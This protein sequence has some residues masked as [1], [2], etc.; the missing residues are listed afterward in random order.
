ME[1]GRWKMLSEAKSR[2]REKM[3]IFKDVKDQSV[4]LCNITTTHSIGHEMVRDIQVKE[5]AKTKAQ[6][7][8]KPRHES[9]F[10]I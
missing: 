10:L 6:V 2:L 1:D 9:G 3:E 7:K 5:K 8:K 4:T